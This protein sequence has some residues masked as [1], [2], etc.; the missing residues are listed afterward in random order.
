MTAEKKK[1]WL[2]ASL[3]KN[4]SPCDV[5]RNEMFAQGGKNLALPEYL[6]VRPLAV[7]KQNK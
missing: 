6:M 7:C 4:C 1:V 2:N 3:E 5:K